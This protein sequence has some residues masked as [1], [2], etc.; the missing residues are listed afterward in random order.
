LQMAMPIVGNLTYE[1]D[2]R[3]G[4]LPPSFPGSNSEKRVNKSNS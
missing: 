1:E 3:T 2:I 4:D